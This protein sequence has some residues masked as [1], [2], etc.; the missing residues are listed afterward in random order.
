MNPNLIVQLYSFCIISCI[1]GKKKAAQKEC[2]Q[3]EY[4]LWILA[5]S[6]GFS[7]LE[8]FLRKRCEKKIYRTIETEGIWKLRDEVGIS[9]DVLDQLIRTAATSHISK[10]NQQR[11]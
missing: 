6:C 9:S 7:D 2:D 1:T 10:L 3:E 5:G 8:A 4:K 11:Y